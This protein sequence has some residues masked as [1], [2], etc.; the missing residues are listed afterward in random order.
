MTGAALPDRLVREMGYSRAEFAA[1]LPRAFAAWQV[2]AEEVDSWRVQAVDGSAAT[3]IRITPIAP[4][5]L[6]ALTL[7]VLEVQIEFLA[8]DPADRQLVL[9]RFERGFQKGGG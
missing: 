8:A 5:R 4:R 3:R 9:A 6:G 1:V 2:V 7:P